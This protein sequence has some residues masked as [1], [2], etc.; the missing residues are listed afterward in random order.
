MGVYADNGGITEPLVKWRMCDYFAFNLLSHLSLVSPLVPLSLGLET[1]P[2]SPKELYKTGF[3]E[4][5]TAQY[6]HTLTVI[7][8]HEGLNYRCRV[9]NNKPFL[10]RF[11][12]TNMMAGGITELA[13][14]NTTIQSW[15]G[16]E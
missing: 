3:N 14:K 13:S 15:G 6:T 1:P 7:G 12:F 4:P 10:Q 5:V 8:R 16:T 11:M 2:L 9:E